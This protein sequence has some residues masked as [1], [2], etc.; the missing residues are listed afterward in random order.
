MTEA[1]IELKPYETL[2]LF[3]VIELLMDVQPVNGNI[4]YYVH[5]V[6]KN[7]GR[8]GEVWGEPARLLIEKANELP[9]IEFELRMSRTAMS[10]MGG[11]ISDSVLRELK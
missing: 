4:E 11:D 2:K 7:N 10:F 1:N 5:A 3:G 8:E 6:N 9:T